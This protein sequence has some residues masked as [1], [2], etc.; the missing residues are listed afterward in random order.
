MRPRVALFASLLAMAGF[1]LPCAA[2]STRPAAD[3][4]DVSREPTLYVVGYA[5]LDTEWR[6]E[7]P[8]VIDEYLSKTLRSNF[9]LFEKYPHY[10]FNFTGANRYMMMQEYYP[11]D[12]ARLKRYV[13]DGRWFP[14]GSSMEENDVN[15]PSA[16]SIIRQV[17]YGN[18]YFR[19]TFGKASEEFML[20]DCFG[21]PASLPSILAH[22]GI[23]GFSTQKLSSAWQPAPRVGGPDSP[24]QTP[25][26]IPFNVGVWTG[27]D[28][29]SVI[30]ALNPGSYSGGVST[31]LSKNNVR[32]ENSRNRS[33]VYDWPDR[34]DLDGKVTGVYADYHYVGTG[35][36]GGAPTESTVKEMEQ[37]MTQ[38]GGPLHVVWSNADQ[39]FKDIPEGGTA[40]MPRYQGDLELINHSAGS[41][42]SQAYHKRWNR[43]N[44]IL[45]GAAEAASVGAAWL[46]ARPYPKARLD[47][48]WRLLLTGQFHDN[49]AG[50]STPK[51]Y[52]YV[53]NDDVI[54]MNQFSTVLTSATSGVSAAL[55]TRGPGTPI[56]V[57]NQLNVARE[58]IA[59]AD[60]VFPGGSP[61]GVRVTGPDGRDV[62]AQV[63][64]V[65]GD[66]AHVV[67]LAA[68][69]SV[70]YA[71]FHVQPA[72]KPASSSALEVSE[73]SL[74]NASYRVTLDEAG[75]VSSIYD[76]RLK[77]ELLSEPIRL[78][79]ST[80]NPEHWPAW[81]MDFADE[82][83]AARAYVG[84]PAEV[85]VV[86]RGPA[87]VAV[88]VSRQTEGSTF[89]TTVRLSAGDA[90]RRVEFSDRID[91]MT[92]EANL[93][94]VFPL[95]AAND[96]ATY[97]WDV[98]TIKRPNEMERQ[99]EVASHRWVDL[100]DRSGRFGVTILT[101]D[102][103]G[104]DKPADNTVRLTLVRTPGTRGGYTD[105]GTQD[106][107]H[108]E[109]VYGL[110]AHAGG[111]R[112]D[113]T[114]W[115]AYRLNEPLMAFTAP[116][117][118]GSL[119]R[120]LSLLRTSSDRVR[121]MALKRAE[122]SDEVVVRLVELDGR[123]QPNVRVD[124]A[125]PLTAAREVNGQEQPLGSATVRNGALVASFTPYQPRTFAV[126]LG[127]AR[128]TIA[129]PV[130]QA[131]ALPY[132]VRV[133]TFDG[134]PTDGC[135]DCDLDRPSAS[136]Q[137]RALAAE[138]LPDSVAYNGIHFHLGPAD[139]PDAVTARGQTIQLP[140]GDFNRV[141]LLAASY[142][143]DQAATFRVGSESVA[144]N[145]E[146][147]GGFIG[148]WDD[149]IWQDTQVQ[150]P[151][152]SEPAAADSSRGAQ[153]ARRMRAMAAE[154]GPM[155][156]TEMQYVGLRPGFIK[157]APVGWFASHDHAPDGSNEAYSYSYLFAYAIDVP[158]GAT[159]LTLPDNPRIRIL[160]ASVARE[161][162]PVTPAHPLYDTLER[163]VAAVRAMTGSGSGS[164]G[165]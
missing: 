100:T 27:P 89:V 145:I 12:F 120:S 1:A 74:E 70:G 130:N 56:V 26:G 52:E 162:T 34:V 37:I 114:D 33:Y 42:T 66:T 127:A 15:S 41:I 9:E 84:G 82:Q 62:P 107:G 75:D 154:R 68:V 137:G 164:P 153:R 165:G 29:K 71:V 108:H 129:A 7:F 44:E 143:G 13:A 111:W 88:E 83:R 147:W 67:F 6:W 35:D 28:G 79:I 142:G 146:D 148:Q 31:D 64:G 63:D 149:R 152:P 14:A 95:T 90:G 23:K 157:R 119:G 131:V 50:T 21:F 49:L 139:G 2:Q 103:S 125:G 18:D 43:K 8:Q 117:H 106:L 3:G 93:K 53:W 99:F 151:V 5:H 102:K 155:W 69:P 80:D 22:A 105:Q 11:A 81:N 121:V 38:P 110:A 116:T 140:V 30:A 126:R 45:A 101:G 55:D 59:H 60:V 32:P 160:A 144:L 76:K 17:L 109:L 4:I 96:S 138:M 113:E 87:R 57:Y 122:Q 128:E 51:S 85:K 104:S 25:E 156:R 163:N 47:Y 118:A 24:E 77:S 124:F 65:S 133:A 39:L 16:E 161:A 158:A 135:F 134:K 72:T 123:S 97:N 20:P 19:A 98:G 150:V 46:G 136:P 92:R 10:I 40:K 54:A 91:W 48:A 141:Y 36:I 78:A 73:T 94:V 86:E 58:D 132:D 159:T 112:Q 61:Q 115:Q